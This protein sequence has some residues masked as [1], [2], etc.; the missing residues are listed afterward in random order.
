MIIE[1]PHG[2]EYDFDKLVAG[3]T[4]LLNRSPVKSECGEYATWVDDQVRPVLSV[5]PSY[6]RAMFTG[7]SNRMMHVQASAM[8]FPSV[9]I[10]QSYQIQISKAISAILVDIAWGLLDPSNEVIGYWRYGNPPQL[11]PFELK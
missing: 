9:I 7:S 8:I 11:K 6:A 5:P 2:H 1:F 10:Y 4:A 3:V